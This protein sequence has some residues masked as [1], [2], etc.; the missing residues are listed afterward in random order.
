MGYVC[1]VNMYIDHL[2][3]CVVCINGRRCVCCSEYYIVSN[4][5]DEHIP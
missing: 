2:K 3:V 5:Y 4:E 1:V